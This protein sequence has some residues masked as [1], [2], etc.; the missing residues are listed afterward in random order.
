[1][2]IQQQRLSKIINRLI[3][4]IKEEIILVAILGKYENG[5]EI[6]E[7]PGRGGYVYA[8]IGG[9][10]GEIVEAFNERVYPAFDLKV[11]LR[12][13][14]NVTD[15]YYVEGRDNS[16]YKNMGGTATNIV[17]HASQHSFGYG[18]NIG[19]DPLWVYKRQF[20]QPMGVHP[21]TPFS[22]QVEIEPDY[23]YWD[24]HIEYFA[25]ATSI[26]FT[27]YK[28]SEGQSRFI[29]MYLD[30][31]DNSIKYM[32]GTSFPSGG[33]AS[34]INTIN[35][36]PNI[37]PG[38]GIPLSAV[39]MDFNTTTISWDNLFDLRNFLNPGGDT[40]TLH[41]L[42]P[43]EGFHTGTI[44]SSISTIVDAGNYFSEDNVEDV[45][46]EIGA[47]YLTTD[48]AYTKIARIERSGSVQLYSADDNGFALAL[49]GTTVNGDIIIIP[50]ITLL[51]DYTIPRGVSIQGIDRRYTILK[52]QITLDAYSDIMSLSINRSVDS[53]SPVMGINAIFVSGTAYIFDTNIYVENTN[54]GG[55]H[56]VSTIGDSSRIE[57]RNVDI[58]TY[59]NGGDNYAL[60]SEN[61]TIFAVNSDIDGGATG[62]IILADNS[63]TSFLDEYIPRI[64]DRS[65]WLIDNNYDLRHS[66]DIWRNSLTRHLPLPTGTGNLP[67]V[68][69][70]NWGLN[71]GTAVRA[72]GIQFDLNSSLPAEEGLLQWDS[73]NGTL[74]FGLPGGNVN[75]QIGQ[76]NLLKV[77]NDTDPAVSLV[78]GDVVYISGADGN[79][80]LVKKAQ[81]N[82][83]ITSA[84]TIGVATETITHGQHGYICTFGLVRSVDTHLYTAGQ[85]IYLSPDTAG[86]F[87]VTKPYAP[88]HSVYLGV[89][90]K[91]AVDGV[92]FITVNNGFEL[93][94]LHDV[95]ISNLANNDILVYNTIT[96]AWINQQILSSQIIMQD[97]VIRPPVPLETEDGTD[98][99]YEG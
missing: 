18:D 77:K 2:S 68:I 44:R 10:M 65:A 75:L 24:N 95:S 83:E 37:E 1:M 11:I 16:Q 47:N 35:F 48:D 81:A 20:M 97:G 54:N 42:D 8:R 32:T 87:T 45:L 28:P 71:T 85:S 78:D 34:P 80:P 3:D 84:T 39:Y 73:E 36:I 79:N 46:Q 51:N 98:W 52:G 96:G 31:D 61:G 63:Y 12:K 21:T 38:A 6:V 86:A 23:Y 55:V 72:V 66:S 74:E 41:P 50:A 33:I 92:I 89:I 60:F 5:Q 26:D 29:T 69:N 56:S 90:I 53:A 58:R 27:N 22:M 82:Q 91:A 15:G 57:I 88:N 40:N 25:G 19:I 7:V 30:G 62:T 14:P 93:D 76:E 70:N 17:K 4:H 43:L 99:L 13:N 67:T 64:G 9:N 49:S 94:E 59:S